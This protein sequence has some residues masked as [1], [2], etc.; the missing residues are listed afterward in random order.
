MQTARSMMDQEFV[1]RTVLVTGSSR[2]IGFAIARRMARGGARV[3]MNGRDAR[4]LASAVGSLRNEGL[5]VEAQRAD[6]GSV[7]DVRRLAREIQGRFGGIDVLVNNAALANP[8][9][10]FLELDLGLW[11]SVIDTN[12]TGAFLCARVA[13]DSMVQRGVP[14]AIVNISSFGA[15]RA[16]RS[17][18]A[19]DAAKG[20]LEA[21]S[22]AAAL[23]LAPFGIRVNSV[24]PG[25]IRTDAS[26]GTP[27]ESARRGALVP[28]GRIGEPDDVAEAVAFLASDRASFVTG[29]TLVVDGGATA[30]LRPPALDTPAWTRSDLSGARPLFPAS[31]AAN[32]SVRDAH[33]PREQRAKD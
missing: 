14:G 28:L 17:L 21:L 20:A 29:Q 2:G 5:D 18:A 30:Q 27:G 9:A 19:Y 25:P 10:H 6:V 12:L 11:R 32:D 1:G 15:I 31:G 24:A 8:V 3:V 16:H 33:T 4:Q 7:R 26:G 22:R 13:A 23:D